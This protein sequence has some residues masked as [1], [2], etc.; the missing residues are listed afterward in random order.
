MSAEIERAKSKQAAWDR[1]MRAHWHIRRFTRN[2]MAEA[3]RVLD[4]LLRHQPNNA[5]ALGDLALALHFTTAFGWTESPGDAMARMGDV[6]RRAVASDDQDSAVQTVLAIHE[7]FSGRHDQA[8]RRLARANELNPNSNFARGYL[9]VVHAF[10]G[11]CD[12]AI[13]NSQAAMRLSP[14]NR[15]SN[16]I[17]ISPTPTAFWPPHWPLWEGPT[18]RA[19]RSV[20][21]CAACRDLP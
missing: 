20:S 10:G 5:T 16:G 4:E 21:T 18:K 1:I 2:D 11:D 8:I 6:A 19:S 9:G 14:P 12:P 17:P 15:Q 13:E 3:I 7:L